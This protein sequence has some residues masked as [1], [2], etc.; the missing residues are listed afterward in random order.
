V[1]PQIIDIY[2]VH[3]R[4][5]LALDPNKYIHLLLPTG[6]NNPYEHSD[7]ELPERVVGAGVDILLSDWISHRTDRGVW[8]NS[9]LRG[10]NVIVDDG[11]RTVADLITMVS[12]YCLKH[13]HTG[14]RVVLAS[15][16]ELH[17]W[18]MY[19]SG[20]SVMTFLPDPRKALNERYLILKETVTFDEPEA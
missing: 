17:D 16:S 1:E 14:N 18:I 20:R 8:G 11:A 4:I 13:N 12:N 7:P 19:S 2:W 9:I 10:T 5:S 15:D 6:F 3:L